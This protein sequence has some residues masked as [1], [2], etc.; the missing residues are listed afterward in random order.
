MAL[1]HPRESNSVT[2][3]NSGSWSCR[4]LPLVREVKQAGSQMG[5]ILSVVQI[6]PC[7]NQRQTLRL[8]KAASGFPRAESRTEGW[9]RSRAQRMYLTSTA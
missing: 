1:S 7:G 8:G 4:I 6:H 3:S 5:G 9:M 2:G